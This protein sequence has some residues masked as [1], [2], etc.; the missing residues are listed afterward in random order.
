MLNKNEASIERIHSA[1]DFTAEHAYVGQMQHYHRRLHL[2]IVRD[3]GRVTYFAS[4]TLSQD[5]IEITHATIPIE[6]RWTKDSIEALSKPESTAIE[7]ERLFQNVRELLQTHI[8]FA[9]QRLY[10][11]L[12]LWNIGT[13]FCQLFNVYPYVYVGGISQSGK[14]KL[15]TLCSHICFNSILGSNMSPSVLF[16]LIQSARCSLFIDERDD[17]SRRN[18][19][20]EFRNLLLNGYK[21]G[22][23]TY[24]NRRT[25]DG[26]FVPE[27]FEVYG[28]KMIANIEGI[29]DVLE[30]RCI[31]ITMRRS[32][33]RE[34]S[35]TEVD[36][37]SPLWQLTRNQIYLFMMR[38]WK[39]VRQAYSEFSNDTA[40]SNRDLELW[41]PVLVL[42]AFFG[43][44][45]LAA[46]M[47]AFSV[48]VTKQTRM[49]YSDSREE[50][51]AEAL[52]SIVEHDDYYA[53]QD[54]R[55]EMTSILEEC[56][57]LSCREVGSLI[58]R[59]GFNESRRVNGRYQYFIRV[60][61]VR[62]LAQNLGISTGG[63]SGGRSGLSGGTAEQAISS[64]S[65]GNG[66]QQP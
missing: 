4:D 45:E 17:L 37:N 12:A 7:K 51:L 54:I 41:K 23:R 11:F 25:E 42:A 21:K 3:D 28:P 48:E 46:E 63:E 29:D 32:S 62:Q 2:C 15:L 30:S 31:P 5:D 18:I 60:S 57:L 52:L 64:P 44:N 9:D 56:N 10:D 59:L 53:A 8:D 33:N 1:L 13:Y 20:E 16:R 50:I 39:A 43:N 26:N 34:I 35:S 22:L 36:E 49:G 19:S 14:T 38:N 61:E 55:D 27:A 40:L 66:G 65:Q 24:R 47:K 6:P 58:R